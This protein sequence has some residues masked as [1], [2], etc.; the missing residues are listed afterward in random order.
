M[1]LSRKT[2]TTREYIG[3]ISTIPHFMECSLLY[4]S[5]REVTLAWSLIALDLKIMSAFCMV[6]Q[7]HTFFVKVKKGQA[8]I[9]SLRLLHT[10]HHERRGTFLFRLP[11][12][13]DSSS[14]RP[15]LK[16]LTYYP[17]NCNPPNSDHVAHALA[18]LRRVCSPPTLS[19]L[20]V[21]VDLMYY[22]E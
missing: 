15:P 18:P 1:K 2:P 20:F 10:W 19:H 8:L 17:F 13:G 14:L 21:P 22:K 6:A 11:R 7:F 9:S 16:L 12:A 3:A 4:A 5:P